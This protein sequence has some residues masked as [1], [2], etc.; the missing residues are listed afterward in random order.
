MFNFLQNKNTRN[1]FELL[2]FEI[3][4]SIC[5]IVFSLYISE[6]SIFDD[7]ILSYSCGNKNKETR[8]LNNTCPKYLVEYPA[9]IE[10]HTLRWHNFEVRIKTTSYLYYYIATRYKRN[11]SFGIMV[12]VGQFSRL[13]KH[14]HD[15]RGHTEKGDLGH[16]YN[17]VE[18]ISPL[19][20][21]EKFI[22]VALVARSWP[23]SKLE[24]RSNVT[25]PRVVKVTQT[26]KTG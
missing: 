17:R 13:R 14:D 15:E 9:T 22:V 25:W 18:T 6:I 24:A 10:I 8:N 16:S 26:W 21:E 12:E 20:F 19:A 1:Y 7:T 11:I 2:K 3:I 5:Y 23:R 4:V